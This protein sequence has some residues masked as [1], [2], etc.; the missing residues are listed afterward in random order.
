[1]G[2]KTLRFR[3]R[4]GDRAGDDERGPGNDARGD[5]FEVAKNSLLPITTQRGRVAVSGVTTTTGP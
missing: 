3:Q 5:L 2:S 1:M 4:D